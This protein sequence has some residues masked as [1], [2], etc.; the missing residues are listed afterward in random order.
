MMGPGKYDDVCTC[1][2]IAAQAE[3]CVLIVFGGHSGSG[4]SCQAP[5]W[6]LSALPEVLRQ[7]ADNI[8]ASVKADVAAARKISNSGIE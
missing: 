7:V 4:F 3:G 6:T 5:A 2:R 1:A 8:E